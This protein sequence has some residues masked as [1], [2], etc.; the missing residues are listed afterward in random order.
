M[1]GTGN[2]NNRLGN[3][4]REA[5]PGGQRT[6]GAVF[7]FFFYII[8][9]HNPWMIKLLVNIVLSCGVFRVVAFSFITPLRVQL[10][11]FTCYVPVMNEVVRLFFLIL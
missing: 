8:E 5:T 1:T 9:S 4:R 6:F 10:V 3:I 11:N 7:F 2:Q